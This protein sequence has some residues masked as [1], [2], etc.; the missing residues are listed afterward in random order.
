VKPFR[1]FCHNIIPDNQHEAHR[2]THLSCLMDSNTNCEIQYQ[3]DPYITVF[4]LG[5]S[6]QH[7]GPTFCST[8]TSSSRLSQRT[9]SVFTH[10]NKVD[11]QL[12]NLSSC[13][14]SGY[15]IREHLH[16][17]VIRPIKRCC[18]LSSIPT[19]AAPDGLYV[20]YNG[21]FRSEAAVFS[22]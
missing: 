3:G 8:I 12:G 22:S 21:L 2:A 6:H 15:P 9:A 7:H 11:P 1:K 20:H 13:R 19:I 10:R 5:A 17:N 16:A 14:D 4:R 18:W